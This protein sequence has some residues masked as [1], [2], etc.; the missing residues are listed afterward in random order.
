LPPRE[1]DSLYRTSRDESDQVKGSKLAISTMA[2]DARQP[3]ST[4]A[5]HQAG[6]LNNGIIKR[7]CTHRRGADTVDTARRAPAGERNRAARVKTGVLPDETREPRTHG[8]VVHDYR[9]SV[10]HDYDA[11]DLPLQIQ[12]DHEVERRTGEADDIC[13]FSGREQ[14]ADG[15]PGAVNRYGWRLSRQWACV[16]RRRE[17]A[18]D[19]VFLQPVWLLPRTHRSGDTE[20]R[21]TYQEDERR[22]GRRAEK[23]RRAMVLARLR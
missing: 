11:N 21:E 23:R 17:Q 18:L 6:A 22:E 13:Q 8:A 4:R 5:G 7:P 1:S 12:S 10:L 9:L 15:A 20:E 14:K 3:K 16:G 2:V 19:R